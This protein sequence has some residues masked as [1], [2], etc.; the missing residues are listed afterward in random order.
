MKTILVWYRIFNIFKQSED[1]DKEG[2]YVKHWLPEL[3]NVPAA[4]V[5][6]PD[7]LSE[8]EQQRF[9]VRIGSDYPIEQ[10]PDWHT[11]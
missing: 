11:T 1:Y 2:S 10:I 6:R 8:I 4:K 9:G 3:R 7:L 5:H